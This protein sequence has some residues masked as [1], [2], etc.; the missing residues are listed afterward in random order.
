MSAKPLPE[1][2]LVS[3]AGFWTRCALAVSMNDT[4]AGMELLREMHFAEGKIF[5]SIVPGAR[6]REAQV[7]AAG[8]TGRPMESRFGG[9]CHVCAKPFGTGAAILY[10]RE[11]RKAAHDACGEIAE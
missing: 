2:V 1:D 4:E 8:F 7:K 9:V 3:S 10:N 11:L 6:Q 5:L